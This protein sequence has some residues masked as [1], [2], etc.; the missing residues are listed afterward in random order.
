MGNSKLDTEY[1]LEN[2]DEVFQDCYDYM[3]EHGANE[4]KRIMEGD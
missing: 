3:S 4:F 1:L 2:P